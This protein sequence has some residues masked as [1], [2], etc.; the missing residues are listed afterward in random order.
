[1]SARPDMIAFTPEIS[2]ASRAKGDPRDMN[3]PPEVYRDSFRAGRRVMYQG[4]VGTVRGAFWPAYEAPRYYILL[5]GESTELLARNH[6]VTAAHKP[7]RAPK[8]ASKVT[9][10][11]MNDIAIELKEICKFADWQDTASYAGEDTVII[12]PDGRVMYPH[13]G[14]ELEMGTLTPSQYA[15][16]ALRSR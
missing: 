13:D 2:R 4:R 10:T 9:S 1:M 14:Q 7:K 16:I 11:P 15:T 12:K 5:D 8:N 3:P 6:Q